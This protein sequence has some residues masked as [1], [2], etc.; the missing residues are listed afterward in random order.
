MDHFWTGTRVAIF[1]GPCI[2]GV[3][4]GPHQLVVGPTSTA[5]VYGRRHVDPRMMPAVET[6]HQ[7][8]DGDSLWGRCGA[9]ARALSAGTRQPAAAVWA[10]TRINSQPVSSRHQ[11]S[12]R[13]LHHAHP[14]VVRF[15]AHAKLACAVRICFL[16]TPPP[17]STPACHPRS[18][19]SRSPL[20]SP[21]PFHHHGPP[22]HQLVGPPREP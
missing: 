14:T 20:A 12:P 6:W 3:Q 19:A 21:P 17:R 13:P 10:H 18:P 11:I 2:A 1:V 5:G 4:Q 16:T 9:C 22:P 7:R 15:T 8:C